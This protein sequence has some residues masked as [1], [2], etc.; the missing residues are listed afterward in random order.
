MVGWGRAVVME[1]KR[2]RLELIQGSE[3]LLFENKEEAEPA[4]GRS[5]W[6]E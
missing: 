2:R 5:H 6:A 1:R 3:N 4:Y